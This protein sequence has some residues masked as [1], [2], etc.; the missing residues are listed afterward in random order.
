MVSMFDIIRNSSSGARRVSGRA[1]GP[2]RGVAVGLAVAVGA[3]RALERFLFEVD[4]LDAQ[5]FA[6]AAVVL[7]MAATAAIWLPARRALRTDP[8]VALRSE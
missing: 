8:L 5:S 7:A 6:A 3:S 4:P 2:G 1:A